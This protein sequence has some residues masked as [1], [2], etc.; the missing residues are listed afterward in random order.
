MKN[1]DD[2]KSYLKTVNVD[3]MK[4]EYEEEILMLS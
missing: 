2:Q 3:M 1:C 4:Q